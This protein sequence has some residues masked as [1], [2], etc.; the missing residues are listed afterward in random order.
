MDER[1][2]PPYPIPHKTKSG[3]LLRFVRGWNSWIHVVF[4]RSYTMKMGEVR[5]RGMTLYVANELSLVERIMTRE[6]RLFPKGRFLRTMLEPLIGNSVFTAN[7]GEWERQRA[8]VNPA[9]SHTA[10]ARVFDKM[11][12]AVDA[13]L[14]R[15]AAADRSGAV[16]I[17]PVMTHFAADVIFRT[18]FS[19]P[20]DA[21]G[22]EVIHRSFA[23]Y[24]RSAQSK[25]ILDVF[26]LPA[27]LPRRRAA[28]QARRIHAV[29]APL[30]RARFDAF[31]RGE[32]QPHDD[33]LQPLL[34][35]RDPIGAHFTF[36]ELMNEVSTIFLAGHETG[37]SAM[38]WA[39]YLLASC[40]HL[41][42]AVRD[43]F[44]AALVDGRPTAET[45]RGLPMLRN[46]FRETLRLYP[47]VSFF[48][49]EVVEP[50]TMR[51]KTMQPASMLL[52]SP[53]LIQRNQDNWQDPHAFDPSRFDDPAAQHACRH[54]YLPFGKGPRVCVGAGFATQEA[55][56]L[57]GSVLLAF[58]LE[59]EPGRVPEPV[60]RLTLRPKRG[61]HLRLVP[62]DATA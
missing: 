4:E 13:T 20:L 47:P 59:T 30:V 37:A 40:P 18:L 10:I 55:L 52:V 60:S 14:G 27:I 9:F 35:A 32:A 7:G 42:E 8:M 36:D 17:D 6:W 12:A 16:H 61:V 38:T 22:A 58:R 45:L 46:V 39:L 26:A 56:L 24:Q 43:E 11:K 19:H 21:D 3:N 53:W 1:F 15:L 34:E 49:R 51:D 28:R 23:A 5:S 50:T 57:L 41:Q 31:H 29:F 33:L 44:R 62:I 48:V 2:V 25:A 54:A